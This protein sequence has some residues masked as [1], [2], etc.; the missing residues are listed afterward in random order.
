MVDKSSAEDLSVETLSSLEKRE[1]RHFVSDHAVSGRQKTPPRFRLDGEASAES[2]SAPIPSVKV[3]RQSASRQSINWRDI[4]AQRRRSSNMSSLLSSL[5]LTDFGDSFFNDYGSQRDLCR[6][7]EDLDGGECG[8]AN[9]TEKCTKGGD[10][11]CSCAACDYTPICPSRRDSMSTGKISASH[12]GRIAQDIPFGRYEKGEDL[13]PK[14]QCS[15]TDQHPIKPGRR[16][17]VATIDQPLLVTQAEDWHN[18]HCASQKEKLDGKS[19][20]PI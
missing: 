7:D 15:A 11:P 12:L 18:C 16:E 2:D 3:R 8:D 4:M 14:K 19:S 6:W 13:V 1:L 5:T 17:S 9:D 10:R 20:A